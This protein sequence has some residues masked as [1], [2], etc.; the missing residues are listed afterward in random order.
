MDDTKSEVAITWQHDDGGRSLAGFTGY[1]GDCVVRAIAIA[2]GMDYREVYDE[3]Y[4]RQRAFFARTRSK[5]V[6]YTRTGKARTG[7][8]REGI[9]SD[10]YKPYLAE[11]GWVWTPTMTIG[12]GVRMHVSWAELPDEPIMILRLSKHLCAVINGVVRDTLD[13]SREGMRAVYGYWTPPEP[14]TVPMTRITRR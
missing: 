8:P 13:P 14:R 1:T 4:A 7:S 9:Y 6:K 11:L 12:S 3:M 10:V 5:R 2:G